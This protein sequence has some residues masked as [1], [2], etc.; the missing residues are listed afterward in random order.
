MSSEVMW[1]EAAL[2]RDAQDFLNSDIGRYIVGRAQQEKAEALDK[3]ARVSTWRTNRIRELQNQVWRADSV[4]LWVTELV[5]AGKQA[6]AVLEE[7]ND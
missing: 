7:L 4:L 6:E 3:L 5:T 2:G 1:A